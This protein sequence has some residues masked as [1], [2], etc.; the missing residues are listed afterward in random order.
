MG[1]DK[2]AKKLSDHTWGSGK[3]LFLLPLMVFPNRDGRSVYPITPRGEEV[4]L[5]SWGGN[6]T[7]SDRPRTPS[8][9]RS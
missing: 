5:P 1:G 8:L 7:I 4:A 3:I 2:Q 6:R 9:R